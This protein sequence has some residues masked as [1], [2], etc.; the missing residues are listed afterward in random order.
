LLQ[1]AALTQPVVFFPVKKQSRIVASASS[2]AMEG[3]N[4]IRAERLLASEEEDTE[5]AAATIRGTRRRKT[6]AWRLWCIH[7]PLSTPIASI[8]PA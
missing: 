3:E 4:E 8:I 5:M 2:K 6:A 1:I 7:L